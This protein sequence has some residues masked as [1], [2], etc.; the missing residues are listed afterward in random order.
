M[1][2]FIVYLILYI[3][4]LLGLIKS[5]K[6]ASEGDNVTVIKNIKYGFSRLTSSFKTYWYIFSYV[7][8][9]PASIFILGGIFFNAGYY[10]SNDLFIQI[11]S[12]LMVL[13]GILF[14]FFA[15]Y[16]GVKAKFSI[17]SAVN[18]DSFKK[19]DFLNSINITTNNWFRI[20][21]NFLLLGIIIFLFG[22]F[23]GG[24]FK[25]FYYNGIDYTSIKSIE[26]IMNIV[27]Q[28]SVGSHLISGFINNIIN[29]IG[30]VFVIIFTYLFFLRLKN[31]SNS[32]YKTG[33]IEL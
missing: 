31:E 29:T 9:I 12:V 18:H 8:L 32:I 6:Q 1:V 28:F 13:G 33:K 4:I 23:A 16:R 25:I 5:I 14:M 11:G 7:A 2:L 27:S 24:L 22:L 3:P 30:S 21:G 17:Y 19:D 15:L 10:F 26:D 20:V